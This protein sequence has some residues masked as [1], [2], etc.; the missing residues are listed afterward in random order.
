M[1]IF[2]IETAALDEQILA[3][4]FVP[5]T[6]EEF[7]GAQRWK[8]ET[9]EEKYANYLVTALEDFKR[10]AALDA[11]TGKVLA[12]GLKS[13]KG[14]VILDSVNEDKLL[15]DFW[16]KVRSCQAAGRSL[17]GHNVLGFD[18][19]FLIRRSWMRGIEF[20][21]P[22]FERDG[23]IKDTMKVWACGNYGETIG[24]DRLAKAL[25][26]PGKTEGVNGADFAR[27]WNGEPEEQKLARQYLLTDLD[28]TWN[29]AN[30]LGVM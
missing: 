18:F 25:G 14:T 3:S 5:K 2:D 23:I 6:K 13:E 12:I 17:V 21:M 24:L 10:R 30:R 7:V 28:V 16:A 11:T 15:T 8:P 1:I 26:L 9:I 29:V 19:P 4:Q 22:H 20:E 27:L